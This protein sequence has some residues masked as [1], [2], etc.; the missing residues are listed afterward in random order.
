MYFRT[1]IMIFFAAVVVVVNHRF[2]SLFG[3]K[4]LLSDIIIYFFLL[5]KRKTR[6]PLMFQNNL[7]A[8]SV[9]YDPKSL[10]TFQKMK[11]HFLFP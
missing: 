9:H 11:V 2:T 10:R 3:T 7:M 1:E 8:L 4:G 5:Q 6:E